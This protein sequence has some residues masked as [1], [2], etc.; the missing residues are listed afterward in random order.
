[1][2]SVPFP[3]AHPPLRFEDDGHDPRAR[4][5]VE[6]AYELLDEEGL[7]GLTIRAVLARTGLARRAFYENFGSKDDLVL[8]VFRQT[9]E[10][11]AR[12]YRAKAETIADPLGRLALIVSSITLGT[13]NLEGIPS[14]EEGMG[15][16]NHR[17]AALSREHLRLADT[18]PREL[19]EAL[20]PLL[21]LMAEQLRAGIAAGVVRPCDADLE[22][23]LIYNLVSTT[24]HTELLAS[25]AG[26]HDRDRR[27]KLAQEIWE[28]CRRAVAA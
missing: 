15:H 20:A 22:A 12:Y 8:A 13:A 11:A 4:R 17:S 2:T 1:M 28:F 5:L 6:A 23:A 26:R 10:L 3:T 21:V 18:H 14:A 27:L 25:E 19:Q 24:V 9:I 16:R 7:E